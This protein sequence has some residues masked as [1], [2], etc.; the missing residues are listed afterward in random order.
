MSI[1][2]VLGSTERVH[3]LLPGALGNAIYYVSLS[4]TSSPAFT[5]TNCSEVSVTHTTVA[6]FCAPGSSLGVNAPLVGPAPVTAYVPKGSWCCSNGTGVT[7]KQIETSGGAPA[8][9]GTEALV[10]T[11]SDVNSCG[12]DPTTGTAVCTAND[13]HVYIINGTTLSA[14]LTSGAT[15]YAGFS[16]GD[17]ENCGLA[18]NGVTHQAV[19]TEGQSGSPSGSGIQFLD[20]TSNTFGPPIPLYR[21]VS[22]DITIDPARGLIVSPD[23]DGYYNLIQFTAT[24]TTKEFN[25]ATAYSYFDSAAEDCST[26]IGL[27]SYELGNYV[28]LTDLT[29]AA[30]TAGTPGTWT[31]P[32]AF[33]PLDVYPYASFSAGT[34][35]IAVAPGN[36]HLATIQGEFG[37][38]T[39]AVL[40]LPATSGSGTPALVDYA[41]AAMPGGYSAGYDPHTMT[42]YTSPNTGKAYGLFT[43]YAAS[44]LWVVD[45]EALLSAPRDPSNANAV[46]STYD[47]VGHGIVTII[48]L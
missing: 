33:V 43:N 37:G 2:P 44:S 31:G 21:E 41:V 32:L 17:C 47:L 29:Q 3:F 11:G 39:F 19:I 12:V 28:F 40:Q 46:L 23:E 18:I 42:A 24:D 22:E 20:L 4:S 34:D 10:A 1:K 16:G 8:S 25:M 36:S 38:N 9:G 5:S 35:G 30:F 45:L 15:S 48:P 14:T 27:S 7:V 26:G 6:T 13:T